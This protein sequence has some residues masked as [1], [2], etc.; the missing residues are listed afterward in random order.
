MPQTPTRRM[1]TSAWLGAR[2]RRLIDVADLEGAGLDE[3]RRPHESEA[4][5]CEQR[6]EQP[7]RPPEP[8]DVVLIRGQQADRQLLG[9]PD[10]DVA[11]SMILERVAEALQHDAHVSGSI[12]DPL[13]E[14]R[15]D[16][17][18]Q[19]LLEPGCD[20]RVVH[21]LADEDDRACRG[22]ERPARCARR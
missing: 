6:T 3:D 22:S 21:R 16:L 4:L 17:G 19:Q 20:A 14:R 13:A 7:R 15:H 12:D 10:R 1:R 5:R 2:D 18:E 9:M 11:Q 8:G